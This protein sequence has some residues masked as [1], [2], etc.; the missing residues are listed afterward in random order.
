MRSAIAEAVAPLRE[1]WP[2]LRWVD[3]SRYHLTVV[4]VGSV[5]Q[6][7][8]D[9]VARAVGRGVAAVGPFTLALDGTLG[10]FGR[11]VLWA[12]LERSAALAGAALA[13][14]SEVAGVVALPDAG[15]SFSAH[16]TL[17]RA[18]REAVRAAAFA[19]VALPR[20]SWEVSSV[21]LLQSAAGFTVVSSF[22]LVAD[23]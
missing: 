1:A 18:G 6:S 5:P 23:A 11:R 7:A 9:D 8:V 16:L 17:A 2:R 21:E 3:P 14:Q 15:R 13:V 20:R 19:D 12:G 10:V 4:F 22:P